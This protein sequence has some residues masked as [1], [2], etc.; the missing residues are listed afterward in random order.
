MEESFELNS[1][2]IL[3]SS[4]LSGSINIAY[5]IASVALALVLFW[6]VDHFILKSVNFL[7]EIKKG[8][9]AAGLFSGLIILSVALVVGMSMR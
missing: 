9:V 6:F 7:D 3:Y 5:A 2:D 8:N 1:W 4:L